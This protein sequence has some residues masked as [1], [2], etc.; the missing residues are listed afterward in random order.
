MIL[1]RTCLVLTSII[2]LVTISTG[3]KSLSL[4]S[5]K[6]DYGTPRDVIDQSATMLLFVL[7]PEYDL[8]Q[9]FV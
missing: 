5:F 3:L 6:S 8:V 9:H 1:T 2:S 7:E 4:K